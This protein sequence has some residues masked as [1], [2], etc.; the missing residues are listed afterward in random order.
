MKTFTIYLASLILCLFAGVGGVYGQITVDVGASTLNQMCPGQEFQIVINAT[1]TY[2]AGNQFVVQLSGPNADWGS[3]TALNPSTAISGTDLTN[4]T[5]RPILPRR[6]D[7]G[8]GY[9]IRIAST[10]PLVVSADI[11]VNFLTLDF[12]VEDQLCDGG[13]GRIR[14]TP[15]GGTPPVRYSINNLDPDNLGDYSLSAGTY[16]IRTTD[17]SG[18]V[19]LDTVTIGYKQSVKISNTSTSPFNCNDTIGELIVD[20]IKLDPRVLKLCFAFRRSD[21]TQRSQFICPD[22]LSHTF[23]RITPGAYWVYL[24]GTNTSCIDSFLVQ[25]L[26][27]RSGTPFINYD[28]ILTKNVSCPDGN[29]GA[30][31]LDFL[32]G[33]ENSIFINGQLYG[34]GYENGANFWINNLRAGRYSFV[35][36]N[37]ICEAFLDTVITAPPAFETTAIIPQNPKCGQN[38]GEITIAV[39]GGTPP[40]KFRLQNSPNLQNENVFTN[41][42]KG[43]YFIET[44]DDSGCVYISQA[45]SLTDDGLFTLDSIT[46]KASCINATNGE[47]RI[48]A[49]TTDGTLQYELMGSGIPAN[50]TGVFPNLAVGSYR[51]RIVDITTG[52]SQD[53]IVAV[54]AVPE[55]IVDF[56]GQ[57]PLC[58]DKPK[59]GRIEVLLTGGEPPFEFSLDNIIFQA[60]N[61]FT[62][63]EGG[64][65]TVYVR[66]GKEKCIVQKTGITLTKPKEIIFNLTYEITNCTEAKIT[67]SASGGAEN[68]QY[69]FNNGAWGFQTEFSGLTAGRD[70]SATARDGNG[71]EIA[72]TIRIPS[73]SSI[74]ILR[75]ETN[76]TTCNGNKDGSFYL[77]VQ[78]NDEL[79]LIVNGME[80]MRS[81]SP[82]V[83]Q[84]NNLDPAIPLVVNITDKINCRK[85][86][87]FLIPERPPIRV[88]ASTV[89]PGCTANSGSIQVNTN[90][91]A[92]DNRTFEFQL[93]NGTF[94]RDSL[95]SG[96]NAGTYRITVRDAQNTAC[97]TFMDV[98]LALIGVLEIDNIDVN[99]QPCI[100]ESNGSITVRLKNVSNNARY[101]FNGGNFVANSTFDNLPAG[102]YDVIVADGSC[103]D[104]ATV[105]LTNSPAIQIQSVQ[106]TDVK[107]LGETNGRIVIQA[108]GGTPPL[109]YSIDNGVTLLNQTNFDDLNIGTYYIVI[110]DANDC[111]VKDTVEIKQRSLFS[112]TAEILTASCT[113]TQIKVTA[114]DTSGEVVY[115]LFPN[116]DFTANNI[117]TTTQSGAIVVYAKDTIGCLKS[118]IVNVPSLA[119]IGLKVTTD[120]VLCFGD[121]SGVI[122]V[123]SKGAGEIRLDL[124]GPKTFT[125]SLDPANDSLNININFLPA[126]EYR[127]VMNDDSNCPKDT[128]IIIHQ[129]NQ[130]LFTAI[131]TDSA[132]CTAPDGVVRLRVSGGNGINTFNMDNGPFQ[133]SNEFR[134]LAGGLVYRFIVRDQNGCQ[135]DTSVEIPV[136]SPLQLTQPI[137]E[138][139][140]KGLNKGKVSISSVGGTE[141]LTYRLTASY[142]K[143]TTNAD[144]T[145]ENLIP[146]SVYTITVRDA[147]GCQRT[148]NVVIPFNAPLELNL[149]VIEGSCKGGNSAKITLTAKNA[150]IITYRLTSAF[151]KDT[152][153]ATGIFEN[154]MPDSVYTI[155]VRDENGCEEIV[156][157]IYVPI[158]PA[159][160]A[161]TSLTNVACFGQENGQIEVNVSEGNPPYSYSLDG[162]DYQLDNIFDNLPTGV[163]NV[164]IK[165]AGGCDTIIINQFI[166]EPTE[167]ILSVTDST[168]LTCF[169]SKDGTIR[170]EISGGLEPYKA[171]IGALPERVVNSPFT[172]TGLEAGTYAVQITD[173]NG[174]TV[175]RPLAVVLTQPT[176]ITFNSST[177]NPSCDSNNDGEIAF[178]NVTGGTPPYEYSTDNGNNF[179]AD[180]VLNN[181][182]AGTYRL[183]VQDSKG[184]FSAGQDVTLAS[185]QVKISDIPTLCTTRRT[186]DAQDI[187]LRPYEIEPTKGGTWSGTNVR[188][189]HFEYNRSTPA[190]EY[191]VEYTFNGCK[192][193]TKIKVVRII[194]PEMDSLICA[195]AKTYILPLTDKKGVWDIQTG[196]DLRLEKDTILTWDVNTVRTGVYY[197]PYRFEDCTEYFP[198]KILGVP[199]A[200]F[201]ISRPADELIVDE[202]V[203]FQN[204][205]TAPQDQKVTYLWSFGDGKTSEIEHPEHRYEQAGTYTVRLVVR[206]EQGCED[207][208]TLVV[209][210]EDVFRADLPNV[211]SPNND[212]YNDFF[213]PKG[214]FPPNLQISLTIYDRWGVLV[215]RYSES[216][217]AWD[218]GNSPEGTYFY[219]LE[220][221][222]PQ[223]PFRLPVIRQGQITLLR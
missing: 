217:P 133:S 136:R 6:V 76:P 168:N 189:N 44:V 169:N 160:Q 104:T 112:V 72:K 16:A 175:N 144:G 131:E 55:P 11:A 25:V 30:V 42:G 2:N 113:G 21:A 185:S 148:T 119:P 129:P 92:G 34:K 59:T 215:Y 121:S 57:N 134:N 220:L 117:L 98:T 159:L 109:R 158:N 8:T 142:G 86:T 61:I 23:T 164:Y 3:T 18:C 33:F 221:R 47:I 128:N 192:V 9:R 110:R 198:L 147:S 115:S 161:Q 122:R 184:C 58:F 70:Y 127:L 15:Y 207:T 191:D 89:E 78:G 63:L 194:L 219:T 177:K 19:L 208:A 183:I 152:T 150:G 162:I 211:F 155:T 222:D 87:I 180:A 26:V 60:S 188:N 171:Q 88:N 173:G 31:Y 37:G 53:S 17:G 213:T 80:V 90:R 82:L 199:K 38:N 135:A 141:P 166:T 137:L 10:N 116:R 140:C 75:Y 163:Y 97:S 48:F 179:V 182:P 186:S 146:D 174:C 187:D 54:L 105:Q 149:P 126:G 167:L 125:F 1:G 218:G 36:A 196:G 123:K 178:Q 203:N 202:P 106:V 62:D 64:D 49:R 50:R 154:L 65:Y 46:R 41:L 143:D 45:I 66:Y 176:Q 209:K 151:G 84:A 108:N 193:S 68:F 101:S 200:D 40:Y 77:E 67:L 93:D 204:K 99:R 91:F 181:L 120:S 74:R 114:K 24:S 156:K 172:F 12:N 14:I 103:R 197:L 145:F 81:V 132:T 5:L 28:Q 216:T 111:E 212:G 205:S 195:N 102:L 157:G 4:V 107:C 85:D 153:N 190:G 73:A 170:L 39:T 7:P 124:T 201:T 100:G 43:V 165:D 20:G 35:V 83:Y 223:N 214:Y 56:S 95:F 210:V 52:C 69:R 138:G 13:L 139:S 27:D 32:G 118:A 22:E 51:V 71:C 29:D 96:L 79:I 130:L 94:T 206:T